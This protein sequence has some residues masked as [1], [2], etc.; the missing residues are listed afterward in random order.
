MTKLFCLLLSS[1]VISSCWA[2]EAITEDEGVLV[3]T[4]AN[5]EEAIKKHDNILVEFYAPWCGHCQKLAPEY[6]KAAQRLA[7]ED[8]P[9]KLAKVDATE[10]QAL[11]D[12]FIT[13]G[14]P[15]LKFFQKG[16]ATDF[17]G[18]RDRNGIVEWLKTKTG[19]TLRTLESV[20]E[21]EEF[22]SRS[23]VVIV[24]YYKEE[25]DTE[26]FRKLATSIQDIPVGLVSDAK[27]AEKALKLKKNG[28]VLFKA[29][30]GESL[31]F[32]DK[33][34]DAYVWIEKNKTPLINEFSQS[35][36]NLIFGGD[37]KEFIVLFY[38][39]SEETEQIKKDFRKA[40]KQFKGTILFVQVDVMVETNDRICDFFGVDPE[41]IPTIRAMSRK[42]GLKKFAPA[43]NKLSSSAIAKFAEDFKADK[44][45]TYLKSQEIPEDW[46]KGLIT[47]I[48]G[49]NFDEVARDPKKHV[50]VEFHA[51]WCAHCQNLIPAWDKLGEL[52]KDNENV[53]IAKMDATLNEVEGIT[54]RALPTISLF[55]KDGKDNVD[56][57][58]ELELKEIVDFL[59]KETGEQ[60]N[61]EV[62]EPKKE[63]E[64]KEEEVEDKEEEKASESSEEHDEL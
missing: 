42:D 40:A 8:S 1:L 24:G 47:V 38:K 35:E 34:A 30:D 25:K 6:A 46:N 56:F 2:E 12:K 62:P 9:I 14:Y 32:E 53:V 4:D 41:D 16:E 61:G 29:S 18:R 31:K 58:G 45:S 59:V 26:Q 48:V 60:P 11:H 21:I 43:K 28:V 19:L 20:E 44:L 51:P 3:L 22:R 50:L 37:Q 23:N 54:I 49:K 39:Q 7:K 64:V 13:R 55:P 15:T 5:F 33:L 57:T 17:N 52:Y 10:N 36:A 63:G 27:I